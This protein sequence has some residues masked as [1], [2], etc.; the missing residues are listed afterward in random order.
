MHSQVAWLLPLFLSLGARASQGSVTDYA[1]TVNLPCPNVTSSPLVR[2]FTPQTQT[3]D[4]R[5]QDYIT[6]RLS[7]VI[8]AAWEAWLGQADGIGYHFDDFKDNLPKVAIALS[9]GGYRAAQFGAGVL[10]GLD[11][12]DESAKSAGTG[13]LLQVASYLAGLSGGSWITSSLY[14][15]GWPNIRDMVLGDGKDLPG[16]LLDLPL[17]TPDGFNIFDDKNEAFYGS[18]LSGVMAKDKTGMYVMC[19]QLEPRTSH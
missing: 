10:S 4:P 12:R 9:G 18:V 8:P 19:S 17:A 11:G 3:L 15:N 6:R 13:G 16:W 7:D 1:P 5:E 14:S 2:V